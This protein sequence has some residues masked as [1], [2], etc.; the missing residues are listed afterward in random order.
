MGLN[1]SRR[2]AWYLGPRRALRRDVQCYW[3]GPRGHARRCRHGGCD[4]KVLVPPRPMERATTGLNT[5]RH[6]GS[7]TRLVYSLCYRR[8]SGLCNVRLAGALVGLFLIKKP[9]NNRGISKGDSAEQQQYT[10]TVYSASSTHPNKQSKS[11]SCITHSCINNSYEGIVAHS[12]TS[13]K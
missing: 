6:R 10:V 2:P 11:T 3:A 8:R 9:K 5:R 12:L 7:R 1:I 13:T 4:S